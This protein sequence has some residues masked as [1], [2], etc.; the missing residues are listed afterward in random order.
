LKSEFSFKSNSTEELFKFALSQSD[1]GFWKLPDENIKE[2]L[3]FAENIRQRCIVV[4]GM[5][6]SSLGAEALY[7]FLN[8]KMEYEKQLLF[9]DTTDPIQLANHLEK[10]DLSSSI[11]FA[12]SKSG[13]TLESIAIL[14]YLDS[15]LHFS[16]DNLIVI[17][18]KNSPLEKFAES[19]NLEIFN[20]PDDV[21]GRYSVLSPSG[22][23][24]LLAVGV[25]IEELLRGAR[26]IKRKFLAGECEN[27]L[28]KA[29]FFSENVEKYSSNVL[30]SY[31]NSLQVFNDWYVQLW[32]ESLGKKGGGLTPIGLIG[33][34]DQHSFLQ[35]LMEGKKDKTVSILKIDEMGTGISIPNAPLP[36]LEKMNV[37]NGIEFIELINLQ[38]E[39]TG[40]SLQNT[41]IPVDEIT[42]ET[43]SE[44]S[45][46]GLVFYFEI[47]TTLTAHKI[48]I[49]PFGQDGVEEG[50]RILKE[51]LALLGDK[52]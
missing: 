49:N 40:E 2:L 24:P 37:L 11:F 9:L 1:S 8:P 44:R 39:A 33:P 42:L 51:K 19:R 15:I 25:D 12:I 3:H 47:L 50:K 21:G 22:L 41:G 13:T 32:G 46:G 18:D 16:R 48:G 52:A 14:K 29:I 35:L 20:I 17:T 26:D 27:I 28:H 23:L 10:I 38:A 31:S 5:G 43:I 6:G 4:I 7:N 34:R 30:F 36:H 45:I